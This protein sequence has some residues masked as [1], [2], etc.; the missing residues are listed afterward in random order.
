MEYQ[1]LETLRLML[2]I[3]TLVDPEVCIQNFMESGIYFS[4]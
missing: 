2:P 1:G 4:Q 3:H